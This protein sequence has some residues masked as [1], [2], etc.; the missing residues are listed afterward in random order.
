VW[1]KG[2]QRDRQPRTGQTGLC[3]GLRVGGPF[4][5]LQYALEHRL[6]E[7]DLSNNSVRSGDWDWIFVFK[8]I[9]LFSFHGCLL[10]RLGT[11]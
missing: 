11:C 9:V 7:E 1:G 5:C 4:V 10:L 6:S 2:G 3:W 8:Y